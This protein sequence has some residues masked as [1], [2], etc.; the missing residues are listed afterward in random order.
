MEEAQAREQFKRQCT[1]FLRH[2][3]DETGGDTDTAVAHLDLGRREG[4]SPAQT[5][6][7]VGYLLGLGL[8]ALVPGQEAVRITL[9]GAELMERGFSLADL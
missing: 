4:L 9:A 1:R 2:L 7:I 8:L 5:E 3:Y 6:R